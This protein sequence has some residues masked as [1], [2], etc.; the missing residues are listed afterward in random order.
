MLGNACSSLN[1]SPSARVD[2]HDGDGASQ[3]Y[4]VPGQELCGRDSEPPLSLLETASATCLPSVS[5]TA[6][7][8]RGRTAASHS[9]LMLHWLRDLVGKTL[10]GSNILLVGDSLS[11]P[12]C[13]CLANLCKQQVILPSKA[14][15]FEPPF[16]GEEKAFS[17][18]RLLE[19]L[20]RT[21]NLCGL[22]QFRQTSTPKSRMYGRHSSQHP[23]HWSPLSVSC[24]S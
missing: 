18:L 22:S 4:Y 11:L 7:W 24:P 10:R 8:S 6:H 15:L 9:N 5:S 17:A 1:A 3:R 16:G 13:F 12:I 23:C 14:T 21:S 2:P 19:A 20:I